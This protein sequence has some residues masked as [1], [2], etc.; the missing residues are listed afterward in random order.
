VGLRAKLGVS[1]ILA[2]QM[3]TSEQARRRLRIVIFGLL[4]AVLVFLI[5][6]LIVTLF[7]VQGCGPVHLVH[8][9]RIRL[10]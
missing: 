7:V 1:T 5:V 2:V 3:E 6:T 4:A 8:G 9:H 10:C